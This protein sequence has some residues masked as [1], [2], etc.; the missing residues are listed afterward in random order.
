MDEVCALGDKVQ[1]LTCVCASLHRKRDDLNLQAGDHR[2]KQ[3]PKFA[4][5]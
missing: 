5:R 1:D 2:S 3:H 4:L